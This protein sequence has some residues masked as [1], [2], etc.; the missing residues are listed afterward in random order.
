MLFQTRFRLF[1]TRDLYA[2][3]EIN[4]SCLPE[5]Y[6]LTSF[7]DTFQKFPLAFIVAE[8]ERGLVGYIM[9]R[10]ENGVSNITHFRV[11]R[12][13]HIVSVAVLPAYRRAGIGSELVLR[14]VRAFFDMGAD[15]CYLEVRRT[16][17]DAMVMYGRLGFLRAKILP[18]YYADDTDAVLMVRP[19]RR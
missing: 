5:N 10:M 4:R 19:L 3:S 6:A 1:E 17:V 11:V 16:N 2:V 12:K 9:G 13:G 7:I 14:A 15:E 8:G 18:K